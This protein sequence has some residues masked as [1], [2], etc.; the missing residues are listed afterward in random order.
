MRIA[1]ATTTLLVAGMLLP[2]ATI[3]QT[4]DAA[5]T[6]TRLVYVP[7][8]WGGCFARLTPSPHTN[9]GLESCN[10]NY[11]TFDC[12]NETGLTS[13]K[14]G[15]LKYQSAQLAYV[16]GDRLLAVINPNQTVDGH[17]YA[18]RIDVLP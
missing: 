12:D 1:I 16:T 2:A 10:P 9:A 17:C 3:A 14:E 5:G 6:V 8:S 4:F 7:G 13:Y 15:S 11:V 18:Q